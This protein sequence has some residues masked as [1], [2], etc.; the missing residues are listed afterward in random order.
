MYPKFSQPEGQRQDSGTEDGVRLCFPSR[1]RGPSRQGP[2]L[3]TAR[4]DP[5]SAPLVGLATM[6]H[7]Q[8][9]RGFFSGWNRGSHTREKGAGQF[10][11]T[12]P[13]TSVAARDAIVTEMRFLGRSDDTSKA[14]TLRPWSSAVECPRGPEGKVGSW[15]RRQTSILAWFVSPNGKSHGI[16]PGDAGQNVVRRAPAEC[17]ISS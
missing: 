12:E 13:P 17:W 3:A 2:R 10:G 4:R 6:H 7:V 14:C 15:H 9:P 1:I 16:W 5:P 8:E 11:R